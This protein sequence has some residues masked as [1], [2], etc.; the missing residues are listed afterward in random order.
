MDIVIGL[1]LATILPSAATCQGRGISSPRSV[2]FQ[3]SRFSGR[4]TLASSRHASGVIPNGQGGRAR[5]KGQTMSQ[6]RKLFGGLLVLILG[7][8]AGCG[9]GSGGGGG[10][11]A[12]S[13]LPRGTIVASLTDAQV[14]TLCDALAIPAG[15]YGKSQSC[16]DAGTQSDGANQADCFTLLRAFGSICPQVTVGNK[17]DCANDIGTDLCA[18]ETKAG[19]AAIRACL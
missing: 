16:G 11:T 15:G 13:G 4:D 9:V 6:T 18:F 10:G 3:T 2:C 19:C 8:A 7:A 12:N 14:N 5:G 1:L 17:E